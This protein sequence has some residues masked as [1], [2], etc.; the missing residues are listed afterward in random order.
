MIK[1][2]LIINLFSGL[3]DFQTPDEIQKSINFL[4]KTG[5]YTAE[6]GTM[7]GKFLPLSYYSSPD[8]WGKYVCEELENDAT[9]C[10]IFNPNDY[11]LSPI[12]S[13][14]G[15][16]LQYERINVTNGTDIYDAS[17]WQIALSLAAREGYGEDLFD[18]V[19]NQN[20]LLFLGHDGNAQ[21]EITKGANRATTQKDGTFTYNGTS[22]TDSAKAF[23]FRMISKQWLAQD[24]FVGTEFEKYLSVQDLPEDNTDYALGKVSWA[25][26]KPITGENAWAFLIGPLQ[27]AYIQHVQVNEKEY[28]PFNTVAIQNALHILDAFEALQSEIG[29]IFYAAEGSLG[30]VGEEPVDPTEIS[31]ENNASALA[32]LWIFQDLLKLS[33]K[34]D[35]TLSGEQKILVEQTID[36]IEKIVD[37]ML[38]FFKEY[39]WDAQEGIFFQGGFFDGQ[40]WKPTLSPKAVDVQTW[41]I[42]TLGQARVDAWFGEESAYKAWEKTKQWGGYYGSKGEL[43][44][45]GYSDQDENTVFSAEWTAGAINLVQSLITSYKENREITTQL[46]LDEK[47]MLSH[48]ITLR[49]DFYTDTFKDVSP[50]NY[51]K[52]LNFPDDNLAFL[53]SN[54]RYFIPFGW[55]AN[56][57]PSTCATSWAL[58]LQFGFNPFKLG[59]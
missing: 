48:L 13:S 1:I 40:N 38:V 3:Y 12:P 54:K 58:M 46:K 44:G 14:P 11:T 43:W 59:G 32:G 49:S 25:D 6:A 51:N 47:S 31:V 27:S 33:K 55:Y 9:V 45:V 57:L 4:T 39:A 35:F 15:Q 19:E 42:T 36:R 2:L 28:V 37:K 20:N 26:W 22:I 34:Y 29:G 41:T 30:N 10:D 21:G 8:Y 18:L 5:G 56:P 50:K 16:E 53:Y 23:Y 17:T 52:L 7:K 24:P